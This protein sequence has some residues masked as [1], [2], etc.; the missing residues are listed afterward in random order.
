MTALSGAV[1]ET[2]SAAVDQFLNEFET[3]KACK[4]LNGVGAFDD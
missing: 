2:A 3:L 1:P 4:N